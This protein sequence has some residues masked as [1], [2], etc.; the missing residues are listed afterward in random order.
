MLSRTSPCAIVVLLL[1]RNNNF[2]LEIVSIGEIEQQ[3]SID[4]IEPRATSVVDVDG[5]TTAL[6][7]NRKQ[8]KKRNEK[9]MIHLFT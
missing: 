2:F 4:E 8:I 5:I 6:F 9:C 7:E 1:L 3:N